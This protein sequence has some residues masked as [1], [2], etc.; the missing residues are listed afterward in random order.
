MEE[1]YKSFILYIKMCTSFFLQDNAP[2]NAITTG[3]KITVYKM[4]TVGKVDASSQPA[5]TYGNAEQNWHP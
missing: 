2:S 3:S 1:M 4:V 5:Q